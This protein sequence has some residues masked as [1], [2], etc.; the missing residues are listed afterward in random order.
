VALTP[1]LIRALTWRKQTYRISD[2]CQ[3]DPRGQ[4]FQAGK[5][6]LEVIFVCG[7]LVANA[8]SRSR[9]E[10]TWEP[11]DD[12][13]AIRQG[14]VF[15]HPLPDCPAENASRPPSAA[16]PELPEDESAAN[17]H[18]RVV[19]TWN[20]STSST[21][22]TDPA[23]GYCL[24]RS[25]KEKITANHLDRCKNCK[26]VNRRPIV[27]TACVDHDVLDGQTYHYAVASV[28]S[29]SAL[30]SF[31]NKA[32][33]VIPSNAKSP[34]SASPYPSCDAE[35]STLRAAPHVKH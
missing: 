12:S 9:Q 26:R 19:L 34:E 24:Y 13:K 15:P 32:T 25:R 1:D 11:A 17:H 16:S 8:C 10:L 2:M 31:S 22:P 29:G 23:V 4:H 35:N 30:S 7:L 21:G 14:P 18:H 3:T 27:G 5:R 33:A 28:R 20:A 6:L